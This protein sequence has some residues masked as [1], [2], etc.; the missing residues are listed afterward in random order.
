MSLLT[1]YIVKSYLRNFLLSLCAFV[2]I[3]LLVDSFE[4]IDNFVEKSLPA[5][6]FIRYFIN[7]LPLFISQV[8]PLAT[9]MAAFGTVGGLSRTGELTAMRAGGLSLFQITRPLIVTTFVITG[10]LFVSQEAILPTSTSNMNQ[11]MSQQVKGKSHPQRIRNRI[12]VRT[13]NSIVHI[14]RAVPRKEL[15]QGITIFNLDENFQIYQRVDAGSA[16]YQNEGWTFNNIIRREFEPESGAMIDSQHHK[17]EQVEFNKKPEDFEQ[18]D[19]GEWELNFSDLRKMAKKMQAEGYDA[20]RLLVNM[21]AHLSTPFA[22][23]VMV[24]LG[25]PFALNRGRNSSLSFGIVISVLVGVVYF[26]LHSVAMA[27]GYSGI[28]PPF[29]AT[30]SANILIGLSGLWLVLFRSQ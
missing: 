12:W 21:H 4:K 9:L 24:L 3:Y 29:L 2:G 5:S 28:L 23:V 25:I 30:W 16:R 11:I 8:A 20:T 14:D 18:I 17:T 6:I 19:P 26:I 22:C 1:R 27:F 15:L 10:L 7:S 13:G